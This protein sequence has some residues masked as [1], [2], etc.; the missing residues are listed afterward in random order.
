MGHHQAQTESVM[1][2]TLQDVIN[3]D[4]ADPRISGVVTVTRVS[5]SPDGRQATVWCSVMPADRS[6]LVKHGLTAATGRIHRSLKDRLEMRRVPRLHFKIDETLKREAAVLAAIDEAK[7]QDQELKMRR[8]R[9]P[10]A[11]TERD[12]SEDPQQ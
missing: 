7:R 10:S 11:S 5:V 2:R 8:D 6:S 1:K 4:L 9:S 3:R 12:V